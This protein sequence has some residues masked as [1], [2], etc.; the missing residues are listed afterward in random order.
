MDAKPG[1]FGIEFRPPL[2]IG[3]LGG[4]PTPMDNYV[5]REDPT[6]H[7]SA[8]TVIDPALSFEVLDDGSLVPFTPT[9]IRFRDSG[10]LR[11]VAPF[12]ELWAHVTKGGD[13]EQSEL[14]PL[15]HELL[16]KAGGDLTGLVYDVAVA[17]RKAARRSGSD[18][19]AFAAVIRSRGDDHHRRRLLASSPA[20]P[21]GHPLVL[22][23]HPIPLGWFQVIRPTPQ[24]LLSVDLDV[25]R[26]RFTPAEGHVYGPPTALAA[27]DPL[28]GRTYDIVPAANRILNPDAA[29]PRY[30]LSDRGSAE[31]AGYFHPDPPDTYDGAG[32][33]PGAGEVFDDADRGREQSWGVVDDTCDGVITAHLVI[34]G[35]H[36]SA[37]ARICVS[38]PDY[39]P[40]RRP[41]L[42]LA[43]DLADR[44]KEPI[45]AAADT[46]IPDLQRSLADLFQRIWETASL[47]N[48]DA[49]RARALSDNANRP[50]GSAVTGP[51]VN[52]NSMRPQDQPWAGPNVNE[53]ID[54]EYKPSDKRVFTDLIKLEHASLSDEYDLLDFLSQLAGRARVRLMVRPAYG[55]FDQLKSSVRA[56]DQPDPDH[57]DPRLGRDLLHDTRMPPYMRDELAGPLSLT[58]RQ[59]TELLAYLTYLDE[60]AANNSHTTATIINRSITMLQNTIFQAPVMGLAGPRVFAG[61]SSQTISFPSESSAPPVSTPLRRWIDARL[62]MA[63]GDGQ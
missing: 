58:R 25:L 44:D 42:S 39:A 27:T 35:K 18:A 20:E 41:F 53:R 7:G 21:G 43:D 31:T 24:Q 3:R 52:Q 9:A 22:G 13:G 29:W 4:A 16:E 34:G 10:K 55:A 60:D 37:T 62:R 19:D 46:D 23:S 56:G 36:F 45:I 28:S 54:T 63:D 32:Q 59:Y 33:H 15:T 50:P 5:W 2:A 12:F 40:D 11:P 51:A 49:I 1:I 61:Y 8:R 30:R 26:V 14:V 57:R 47:T 38:P 6:I 17:N 48:L